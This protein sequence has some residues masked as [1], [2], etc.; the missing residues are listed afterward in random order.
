MGRRKVVDVV[1]DVVSKFCGSN[2]LELIDV[3]FVK[4]GPHR[5]LRVVIDKEDGVSLDD[6]GDVS[7][8]LNKKLDEMDLIEEQYF[9]EVTSPGVERELKRDEDFKKYSGKL[10]Q[11]KL[12]QPINGQKVIQGI[13][14]GLNE[15]KKIIIQSE[16]G[17]CFEVPKSKVALV[18]LVVD[19][20]KEVN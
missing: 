2:R 15:D 18:K 5:Y 7:K 9:L 4:E 6:C 12:F 10:V 8:F 14:N 13:L 3:Q 1:G 11:A 19:F 16:N 17:E 20:D